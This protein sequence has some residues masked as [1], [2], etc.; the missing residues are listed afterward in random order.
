MRF[1]SVGEFCLPA[2]LLRTFGWR[3]AAF[4]F[5]WCFSNL[6][7]VHRILEDD[8]EKLTRQLCAQKNNIIDIENDLY[9]CIAHKDVTLPKDEAYYHRCFTRWRSHITDA[10]PLCLL[11]VTYNDTLEVFTAP[12]DDHHDRTKRVLA[13]L[14]KKAG[15]GA[16]RVVLNLNFTTHVPNKT[17]WPVER[18]LSA[19]L[20]QREASFAAYELQVLSSEPMS[21]HSWIPWL[22]DRITFTQP[23]FRALKT[24]FKD[25]RR[26]AVLL[27]GNLRQMA[28]TCDIFADH[29]L[30]PLAWWG[31]VDVFWVLEPLCT[32]KT[33]Y[34]KGAREV[35]VSD[36][37]EM[38]EH[39]C[40]LWR[41]RNLLVTLHP[42]IW[43]TPAET[44]E[45]TAVHAHMN[46]THP[47]GLNV[48][49]QYRNLKK[50]LDA[51]RQWEDTTGVQFTHVVKVRPDLLPQTCF[52][53]KLEEQDNAIVFA[54]GD[55]KGSFMTDQFFYGNRH[56]ME[57]TIENILPLWMTFPPH[58]SVS[59]NFHHAP[60][61]QIPQIAT[62][63]G[64]S[65]QED[66]RFCTH[67]APNARS[68]N[69]W[70]SAV[71]GRAAHDPRFSHID[72]TTMA[73]IFLT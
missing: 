55:K 30:E 7:T 35:P 11:H 18:A 66:G 29:I 60:E 6:E 8:G 68:T 48:V 4:P 47:I 62:G 42:P 67:P 1:V 19:Y 13:L 5:D 71:C 33:W 53:Y 16:S 15:G 63:R 56:A 59:E 50:C 28:L 40:N 3:E 36:A 43:L 20:R 49:R 17:P 31:S 24:R 57:D 70:L 39:I 38:L 25:P 61:H 72:V 73:V 27:S 12:P 41:A 23:L 34:D 44:S 14:Q 52:H 46:K 21:L 58:P 22:D 2:H 69:I 65:V 64:W 26:T 32:L 37:A 54:G 45:S 51:I 10:T 9:F